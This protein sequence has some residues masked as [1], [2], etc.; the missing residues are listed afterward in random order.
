[1]DKH[2]RPGRLIAEPNTNHSEREWKHWFRTFTNFLTSIQDQNPDKLDILINH[3]SPEIY[4]HVADAVSYEDAIGILKALFVKSKNEVYNRHCLMSRKQ[5]ESE[6]LDEY[7]Q[8]LTKLSKEC[9]FVAVTAAQYCSEYIRDAFLNGIYSRDV[10]KRLLENDTLSKDEAFS[11]A[12]AME[13][14]HKH[15]QQYSQP[16]TIPSNIAAISNVDDLPEDC[17]QEHLAAVYKSSSDI[18][19]N[20]G[21]DRHPRKDCPARN[22]V[23]KFCGKPGHYERVCM[24]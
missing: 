11:K 7:I 12:R 23:C 20:C 3:V 16:P 15:S 17:D 9:T 2:L 8:T 24:S 13:M 21:Y 5:K 4:E 14:A 10:L 1:M 6:S 22:N 18:C 19:Y